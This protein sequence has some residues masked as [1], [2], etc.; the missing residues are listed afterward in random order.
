MKSKE[1]CVNNKSK[2]HKKHRSRK[3]YENQN[4]MQ[5]VNIIQTKTAESTTFGGYPI[6]LFFGLLYLKQK[7]SKLLAL[8]FK[9]RDLITK[10]KYEIKK[11]NPTSFAGCLI[12]RCKR[13]IIEKDLYMSS[14]PDSVK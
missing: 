9:I 4:N 12:Y 5:S 1:K 7:H 13:D 2:N 6:D 3:R 8:P 14:E 11:G 10:Y